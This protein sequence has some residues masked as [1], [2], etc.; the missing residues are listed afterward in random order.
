MGGTWIEGQG[1]SVG[2]SR[3]FG[4]FVPESGEGSEKGGENAGDKVVDKVERAEVT[5][6]CT[7]R[8]WMSDPLS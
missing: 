8:R 6:I 7:V 1:R 5:R 3:W 2:G 4:G